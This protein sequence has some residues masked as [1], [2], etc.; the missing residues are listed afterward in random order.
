MTGAGVA[1]SGCT[2]AATPAAETPAASTSTAASTT[3]G[4]GSPAASASQSDVLLVEAAI[5]DERV[6][7]DYCRDAGASHRAI[8]AVLTRIVAQQGSHVSALRAALA[9]PGQ[10]SA[11]R[12]PAVRGGRKAILVTVARLLVAAQQQRRADSL[13]AESGPLARLF[14][15]ISASHAVAAGLDSLQP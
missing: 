14:A 3:S 12:V 10:E 6:L 2:T 8:A 13:A 9:D 1:L 11:R 7:L 15:S 4:A 5:A